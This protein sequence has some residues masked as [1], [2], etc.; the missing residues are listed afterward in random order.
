[1]GPHEKLI[2][3]L[4][5]QTYF[6]GSSPILIRKRRTRTILPSPTR[7]RAEIYIKKSVINSRIGENTARRG[8]GFREDQDVVAIFQSTRSSFSC[9][10]LVFSNEFDL[11]YV[12]TCE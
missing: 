11:E 5:C 1:M 8:D 12:K 9:F 6:L 10:L 3:E 7:I 2:F 4:F